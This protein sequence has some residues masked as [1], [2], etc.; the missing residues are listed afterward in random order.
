MSYAPC[1]ANAQAAY[2]QGLSNPGS[3]CSHDCCQIARRTAPV[4]GITAIKD[5]L[6][7]NIA[8]AA[9]VH[10]GIQLR[11]RFAVAIDTAGE[12]ACG[13]CGLA[14]GAASYYAVGGVKNAV[15]SCR[16]CSS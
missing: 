14:I 3:S 6:V 7:A 1:K 12:N 16:A 15:G 4:L 2:L 8:A 13:T 10:V 9:R 11:L 5:I